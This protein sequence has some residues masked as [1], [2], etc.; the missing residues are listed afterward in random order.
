MI[1]CRRGRPTSTACL[2]RKIED[3]LREGTRR[4]REGGD[5]C[6]I[7]YAHQHRVTVGQMVEDLALPAAATSSE[8]WHGRIEYLPIG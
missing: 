6:G 3:L 2:F 5:F 7:V 8:E 4:L 1:S